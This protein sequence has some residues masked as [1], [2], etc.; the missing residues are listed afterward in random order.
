MRRLSLWKKKK[1]LADE[2]GE[3]ILD[4]KKDEHIREKFESFVD[5]LTPP[6]QASI[7]GFVTFVEALIGDDVPSSEENG[8]NVVACA[9]A[10]SIY[11]RTGRVRFAGV[12]RCLAR[13]GSGGICFGK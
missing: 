7:K 4:M 5:L 12:Q 6:S 13:I 2:E 11:S 9:R 3:L 8:L 1:A 10:N